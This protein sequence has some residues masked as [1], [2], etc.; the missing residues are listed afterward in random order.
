MKK[1]WNE[2]KAF[3]FKGNVVDLAVGMIIGSSFTAIVN[4]LV[5]SVVMPLFSLITQK[6][7][8]E[9]MKWM[10]GATEIPY[11]LFLQAVINFAA[12]AVCLFFIVKVINKLNSL[13]RKEEKKEEVKEPARLCPFCKSEIHKEATRCP[14]CTSELK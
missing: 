4:S 7:N 3:A 6:N 2:F 10:I 13:A 1:I 11:G 12:I 9:E 8:Y 5:N 14:H